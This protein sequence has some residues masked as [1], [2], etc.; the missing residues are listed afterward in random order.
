M[1][2]QGVSQSYVAAYQAAG[3]GQFEIEVLE[4]L[5]GRALIRGADAFEAWMLRQWGQRTERLARS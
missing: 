1:C 3:F 2:T 4:W 5:V